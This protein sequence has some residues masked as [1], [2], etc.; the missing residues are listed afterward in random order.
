MGQPGWDQVFKHQLS[1]TEQTRALYLLH[2]LLTAIRDEGSG[3]K[4]ILFFPVLIE[5]S[6]SASHGTVGYIV[7]V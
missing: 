1:K 7:G 4:M 6:R 3:E 2:V 5:K